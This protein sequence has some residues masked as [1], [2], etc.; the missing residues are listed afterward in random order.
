MT[1]ERIG[2]VNGVILVKAR[3]TLDTVLIKHRKI[4]NGSSITPA[5]N[6]VLIVTPQAIK[7][8]AYECPSIRF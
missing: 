3:P 1:G 7:R 6:L 2:H 8:A 5:V 4:E